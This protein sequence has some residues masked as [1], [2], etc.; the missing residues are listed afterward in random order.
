[1]YRAEFCFPDENIALIQKM[2]YQVLGI[3]P[4]CVCLQKTFCCCCWVQSLWFA[5]KSTNRNDMNLQSCTKASRGKSIC[6][7][8]DFHFN[9][10]FIRNYEIFSIHI[11]LL[12]FLI[13]F[14]KIKLAWHVYII[15][16]L[17]RSVFENLT[18]FWSYCLS[19]LFLFNWRSLEKWISKWR[20]LLL[21][22]KKKIVIHRV[23]ILPNIA[24]S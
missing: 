2:D 5:E 23:F 15:Q 7:N 24:V 3:F 10:I 16:F 9:I 12:Y 17:S 1:M 8:W 11:V 14:W 13:L 21:F 19:S 18:A 4:H 6:M 22:L 20:F